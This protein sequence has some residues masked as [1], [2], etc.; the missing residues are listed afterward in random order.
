MSLFKCIELL[1][2]RI[3]ELNEQPGFI[4]HFINYC[5][6]LDNEKLSQ[7]IQEE[8]DLINWLTLKLSSRLERDDY[9]NFEGEIDEITRYQDK[10]SSKPYLTHIKDDLLLMGQR[11]KQALEAIPVKAQ[12]EELR[13]KII[14]VIKDRDKINDHYRNEIEKLTKARN[15][16]MG[17]EVSKLPVGLLQEVTTSL[18]KIEAELKTS[19]QEEWKLYNTV[20]RPFIAAPYKIAELDQS[21]SFQYRLGL[22]R[23]ECLGF[24]YAMV[25]PKLS[26]YKNPNIGPDEQGN[27]PIV[28]LTR[29]VYEYQNGQNKPHPE[30]K[31]IRL[32]RRH[33]CPDIQKQVEEIYAIAVQHLGEELRVSLRTNKSGHLV[34][35]CVLDR[36]IR[37]TD[38]S[39]GVYLFKTKEDFFHFYVSLYTPREEGNNDPHY[40]FYQISRLIYDPNHILQEPFSLEGKIRTIL[41][42]PKYL[43]IDSVIYVGL[44]AAAIGGLGVGYMAVVNGTA[45][46]Y[47]I[48]SG[49][50]IAMPAACL[51]GLLY[52]HGILGPSHCLKAIIHDISKMSS[53]LPKQESSST[54]QLLARMPRG[55]AEQTVISEQPHFQQLFT[56]SI[57]KS[58][59]SDMGVDSSMTKKYF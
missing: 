25:D 13:R 45:L 37:Y 32:T 18:A 28:C 12:E 59:E 29:E 51:S 19:E 23:G 16:L 8:K 56:N 46:V 5:F 52:A 14:L 41:T 35:L 54:A 4:T 40:K 30:I 22:S 24:T 31:Q 7:A 49:V 50:L 6:R 9:D 39:Q 57:F 36:E 1:N 47:S 26:P 53:K 43:D 2:K 10:T 17:L 21:D 27:L 34:Y 42:G 55:N 48:S 33:F 15:R 3:D 11:R 44:S 38:P 20:A 58:T